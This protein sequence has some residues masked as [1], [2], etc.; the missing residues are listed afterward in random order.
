M[1]DKDLAL[2]KQKDDFF[3]LKQVVDN[4]VSKIY[5]LNEHFLK[6]VEGQNEHISTKP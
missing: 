5:A 6:K 2:E 1:K 3:K 4:V